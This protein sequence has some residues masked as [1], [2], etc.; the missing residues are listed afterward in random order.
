MKAPKEGTRRYNK[1]VK[2]ICKNEES[3]TDCGYEYDCI[4]EWD[5][6]KC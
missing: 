4:Y 2:H 5:C 1:I 6:N 3:W